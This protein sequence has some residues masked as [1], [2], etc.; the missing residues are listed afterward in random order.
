MIEPGVDQRG[1]FASSSG[2]PL[3]IRLTYSLPAARR[4]RV[5]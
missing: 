5:R 4:E 1:D 3:V 2:S